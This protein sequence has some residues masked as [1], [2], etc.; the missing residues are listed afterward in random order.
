[1]ARLLSHYGLEISEAMVFGLSGALMFAY[2]PFVKLGGMPLIAYRRMPK[3]IIKGVQKNLGI[4][5]MMA[6]FP[7][8]ETG[9]RALDKLLAQG[10]IAGLQSSVFWL[11]YFPEDMRFHFNAHNLIAYGKD[12]DE[13]LISDPVF[14][15]P[16]R[17]SAEAL[18]KAR[19]VK[20]MMAP[21]GLLYYP[22]AAPEKIDFATVIPEV[23]KKTARAMLKTPVPI[24]GIR[25]IYALAKAIG[26]LQHK[27]RRYA[28][29]FLGH[30]IRMQEEIGT[31]GAGF[32]FIYASFLQEAGVLLGE[33]KLEGCSI[34]MTAVGDQW[35]E[36]ALMIA[37]S[38]R[39]KSRDKVINFSALQEKLELVAVAEAEVYRALLHLEL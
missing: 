27:D 30:I 5:M 37:K 9:T 16:V 2:I 13:Y 39:K 17:C 6:T 28:R 18:E 4:K 33:Q 20:G 10:Q 36:F 34:M 15:E 21:K 32:R 24:V 7:R 11:P 35:R 25:A 26:R 12:G 38:I 14:E 31:G 22:V 23:I 8:P 29:L 3:A 19:F 1:M